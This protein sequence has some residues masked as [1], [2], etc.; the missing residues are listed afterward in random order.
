MFQSKGRNHL[1]SLLR[2]S[3]SKED[4]NKNTNTLNYE[5][6][7]ICLYL[8]RIKKT[9]K[10]MRVNCL[11]VSRFLSGQSAVELD[12]LWLLLLKSVNEV[13]SRLLCKKLDLHQLVRSNDDLVSSLS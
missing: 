3:N 6:K 5:L 1:V 12:V 10:N 9:K 8:D 13:T 4:V 2:E 7:T 11:A